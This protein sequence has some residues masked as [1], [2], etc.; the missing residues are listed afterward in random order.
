M[1]QAIIFTL[2]GAITVAR[3]APKDVA[4]H[5]SEASFFAHYQT[6]W[7]PVGATDVQLVDVSA[8]P[9]ERAYRGAWGIAGASIDIDMPK[10]RV[11]AQDRIRTAREPF[12]ADLDRQY[13]Q[14]DEQGDATAKAAIAAKKNKL[15]DGP[16]DSRLNNAPTPA[17]LKAAEAAGISEFE[18]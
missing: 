11:I 18:V 17:T 15:R 7:L 14:A 12:F 2:N 3:I 10:A 13:F 6:R 16:S 9:S 4:K 5:G 1:A 8:I